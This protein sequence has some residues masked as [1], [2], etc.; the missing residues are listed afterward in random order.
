MHTN[1]DGVL[2]LRHHYKVGKDYKNKWCFLFGKIRKERKNDMPIIDM[3]KTGENIREI[4]NTQGIKVS[5]IQEVMG[6]NTPQAIYKWLRG[7]SLP[8]IDNILILAYVLKV[9]IEEILII[10]T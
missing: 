7:E 4:M 9:Q 5:Q 6:F 2:I 10:A 1:I 8:S 3:I